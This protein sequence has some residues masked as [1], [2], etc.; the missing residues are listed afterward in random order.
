MHKTTTVTRWSGC[1]AKYII[2]SPSSMMIG[3]G[4]R[5]MGDAVTSGKPA[6]STTNMV[7]VMCM[8]LSCF[9]HV[10]RMKL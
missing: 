8:S 4:A 10:E 2:L 9:R 7:I 6:C 5:G 3:S 1:S